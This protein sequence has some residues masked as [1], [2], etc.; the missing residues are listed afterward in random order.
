[1]EIIIPSSELPQSIRGKVTEI[2]RFL[3]GKSEFNP[4][5]A[6]WILKI[7]NRSSMALMLLVSN[8]EG[9][10]LIVTISDPN[11]DEELLQLPFQGTLPKPD[12][13]YEKLEEQGNWDGPYS[14]ELSYELSVFLPSCGVSFG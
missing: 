13:V 12:E 9:A 1:M 11:I 4:R 14:E 3:S 10:Q 8:I 5:Q 6:C 2:N 7:D